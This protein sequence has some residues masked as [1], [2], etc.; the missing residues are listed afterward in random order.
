MNTTSLPLIA[1]ATLILTRNIKKLLTL[2]YISRLVTSPE[3]LPVSVWSD[4]RR[5]AVDPQQVDLNYRRFRK[6]V[7]TSI[8]AANAMKAPSK[9]SRR[10]RLNNSA[11]LVL[12]PTPLAHPIYSAVAEP[13]NYK[14]E[15][16]AFEAIYKWQE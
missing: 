12:E 5:D 13:E 6:Y 10:A 15:V 2:G 11:I 4:V 16:C 9:R 14:I 8:Q 3:A 7:G 1:T